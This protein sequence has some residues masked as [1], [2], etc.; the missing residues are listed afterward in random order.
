MSLKLDTKSYDFHSL[1]KK[2][3]GFNGPAFKIL[4]DGKDVVNKEY[5]A[6]GEIC[7]DSSIDKADGFYF[8]VINSY[9]MD[10]SSFKWSDKYFVAGNK[11]EIK[12]GY[13]DKFVT[14][15]EGYIT[16]VKYEFLQG[17][18][19][20]VVLSGMD[21]S[22]LM[23]KGKKSLIWT[24]K[25]HSDIVSEIGKK[26]KLKTKVDAT[27]IKF[28]TIIQ[29]GQTDYEF[30][31]YLAD[32]NSCEVFTVGGT[33]YFRKLNSNKSSVINLEM[34]RTLKEFEYAHDIGDQISSVVVRGYNSMKE[35]I[36]ATA[37]SIDK[38]GSGNKDGLSLLRN[39]DKEN[40]VH[41][42]Y[43]PV[44]SQKEAEDRAKSL[45]L[46]KSMTFVEGE[47]S[48]VGIPEIMAGRYITIKGLW[49]TKDRL[50]YVTNV[51]HTYDHNGFNSHFKVGG[52]NI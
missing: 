49:G 16:R 52:N 17:E 29:N 46:K 37:K 34:N 8:T 36:Q 50:F 22:F 12:F 40:T 32:L 1:E 11:I 38:L 31:N 3:S 26:Y 9:E 24:K 2:Y 27:S 15:F 13:I 30:I 25:K 35:E 6:I 47:G 44:I 48:S 19:P 28:E 41:Y 33:L 43:D 21:A 4:I 39:L 51:S 7:V 18:V 14:V 10:K 42:I 20:K 45:L 23:M 5:M